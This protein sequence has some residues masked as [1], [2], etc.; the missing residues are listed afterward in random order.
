MERE[1]WARTGRSEDFFLWGVS[2][3][4]VKRKTEDQE[5]LLEPWPEWLSGGA[6]SESAEE[7]SLE[8]T[9]SCAWGMSGWSA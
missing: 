9:K 2:Q 3:T 7:D 5:S 6:I 4:Q 1:G 8:K